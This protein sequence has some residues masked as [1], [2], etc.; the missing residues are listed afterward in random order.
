MR[1]QIFLSL[2]SPPFRLLWLS[3]LGRD[4]ADGAVLLTVAWLM[5]ELTGSALMLGVLLSAV[6][7]TTALV[8]SMAG[9]IADWYDRRRIL[10]AAH[11]GAALTMSVPAVLVLSGRVEVWHL[12]FVALLMGALRPLVVPARRALVPS[13]IPENQ[14]TNGVALV[15]FGAGAAGLG[16]AVGAG[17]MLALAGA[18]LSFGVTS[19][20]F[21]A[22]W[23]FVSRM[24]T[25][26]QASVE[27]KSP[28]SAIRAVI[29][30]GRHAWR[31]STIRWV[32]ILALVF[33]AFAG[34]PLREALP[35]IAEDVSKAG[36]A[37]LGAL[38]VASGTGGVVGA[39]V[40]ATLNPN[41]RR[42][43]ILVRVMIATGALLIGLSL[44]DLLP[45]TFVLLALLG[46]GV[47]GFSIVQTSA[48]LAATPADTR[49]RIMGIMAPEWL[50]VTL[51][52]SS[53]AAGLGAIANISP[54]L[55]L[56]M[57]GTICVVIGTVVLRFVPAIR[58]ID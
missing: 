44:S 27:H 12:L 58:R 20:M 32:I 9:V 5:Y 7:V 46:A 21:L 29:D 38:L 54:V 6:A 1:V 51:L 40:L 24:R 8:G 48:L 43:M 37:G 30:A 45:L 39:L 50:L 2:S 10:S 33:A 49:G 17:L 19:A 36:P 23:Y 35:T 56:L 3:V 26:P 52:V 25:P 22:A 55:G 13:L 42:G 4:F 41:R 18:G 11:L 31:T 34:S 57:Y 53:A 47:S 28:R 15:D 14:L 16:G